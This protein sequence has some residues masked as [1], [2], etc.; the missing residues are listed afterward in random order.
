MPTLVPLQ[1]LAVLSLTCAFMPLTRNPLPT[2]QIGK[3]G[4]N[5]ADATDAQ[6]NL[7]SRN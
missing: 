6:C 7:F 1:K 4:S 2:A 3:L 5:L